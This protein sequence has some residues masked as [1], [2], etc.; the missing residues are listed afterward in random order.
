MAENTVARTQIAVIGWG[1]LIWCPGCL[2]ISTRW[3]SDGPELPIEFARISGD[4]RLT[5]VIHPGSD[6][7]PTPNQRSYWAVTKSENLHEAKENLRQ[8]E[9]TS[10]NDI[11]WL[12]LEEKHP[13]VDPR[14]AT[15]IRE[16]LG[17]HPHLHAAIWTGLPSNWKEKVEKPFT[18]E[19]AIAYLQRLETERD[20]ANAAFDRAREYIRNTPSQIQ[21]SLRK[22]L[23]SKQDW[24]DAALPALLFE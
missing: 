18:V 7:E 6:Q 13:N 2:Q 16:W 20:N 21:T 24:K 11:H 4:R 23:K 15:R 5:L 17:V 10:L 19:D 22:K 1:S 14:V 12:T 8:R 9:R 3:H